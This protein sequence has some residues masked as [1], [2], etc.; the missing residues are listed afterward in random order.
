MATIT[1]SRGT[2]QQT[3]KRD[4]LKGGNGNPDNKPIPSDKLPGRKKLGY[5]TVGQ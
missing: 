5:P 3:I 2:K 1:K 4:L